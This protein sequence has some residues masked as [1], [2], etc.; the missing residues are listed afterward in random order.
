MDVR[1]FGTLIWAIFIVIAVISSILRSA[2]R[3]LKNVQQGQ[4]RLQSQQRPVAPS[5]PLTADAGRSRGT[6]RVP[7]PVP[8]VPVT[9]PKAALVE[10]RVN[11]SRSQDGGAVPRLFRGKRALV[12]GVIALEVLGPPRALREWKSIV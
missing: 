12:R 5:T 1:D 11:A 2:N 4:Q 6:T 10:R 3:A 9:A 7:P 8:S